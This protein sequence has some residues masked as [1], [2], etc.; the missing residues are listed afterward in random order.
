MWFIPVFLLALLAIAYGAAYGSIWAWVIF[1]PTTI[2]ALG[3]I[4][5]LSPT[6][7]VTN[8]DLRVGRAHIPLQLLG[9]PVVVT[10][11]EMTALLRDG[12]ARTFLAVRTWATRKG[13]RVEVQDTQ[14]PHG[15]WLLSTRHPE[16]L[17]AAIASGAAMHDNTIP[18]PTRT[19]EER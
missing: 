12:D 19:V 6:I 2:A 3:A 1:I 5:G 13:V 15:H 9:E 4:V 16:R 14:D 17:H 7:T 18:P 11:P 10:P 8:T